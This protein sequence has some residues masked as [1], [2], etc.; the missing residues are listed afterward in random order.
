MTFRY[1][2]AAAV[3]LILAGSL[4]YSS[5]KANTLVKINDDNWS[6]MLEGEWMVE[7]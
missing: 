5:A 1:A 2:A 6:Q 4:S 7:L 3:V